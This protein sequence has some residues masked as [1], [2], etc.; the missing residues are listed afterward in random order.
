MVVGPYAGR[1]VNEI[2]NIIKTEMLDSGEALLYSEPERPV[3]S[4]SGDECVVAL[5]DQ[6]YVTYGEQEWK[7]AT[8]GCLQKM[9]LYDD[10]A[11]NSFLHTLD[12][13]NQWACSRS[14]GLGTR[15]PWDPVYL[16]E[17]LSDST[18]YMAY[19]TVAHLLQG[20]DMYCTGVGGGTAGPTGIKPEDLTM[21]V[22]DYVFLGGEMPG[23]GCAVPAETL[24]QMRKEFEYWYPFDLRVSGKD[25]I[26]NHLTFCL[27]NHTAVWA[28]KPEMWPRSMRSN[29][30]LLLNADKMSKSTGNFK[31]LAQ[32]ISEYSAD[33]MR[34]AL[35]DAGDG[36]DDANFEHQTANAAILR[37]TKELSWTEEVMAALDTMRDEEPTSFIDRVFDNEI[38]SAIA[39]AKS[40][41]DRF[42]FRE[43]LKA[44]W[45]DISNARDI[46]RFACG[47]E[48]MNKR[49]ILRYIDVSTRLLAP[50]CPHWCEHVWG[51]ILKN[52]GLV[53]NAGWPVA[54]PADLMLQQMAVY[55]ESSIVNIRK[56][57]AKAEMASKPKKGVVTPPPPTK[58]TSIELVVPIEFGG[59]QAKVLSLL[60]ALY[61]SSTGTFPADVM[62]QVLSASNADPEISA[63]GAKVIK[64]A[65]MPFARG[66]IDMATTAGVGAQALDVKMPF[67]E[68]SLLTENSN[69]LKR[70]L[71]VD[72]VSVR[73]VSH[74]EVVDATDVDRK[75]AS[76][77]PGSPGVLC[78]HAPPAAAMMET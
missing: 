5:T 10:S 58:V 62:G 15:L 16:I 27:Y 33:A 22:W 12:W 25:L 4:R 39:G 34:V 56:A 29:G 78:T 75:I 17:S 14:F 54:P 67:D 76:A 13:L 42:M 19:Y 23:E 20:G 11:K 32:A 38:N 57:I 21:E 70:S 31:T 47:A 61:D 46:Y 36:M 24:T 68:A 51:N 74:E 65:V 7:E 35:A 37:L 43:A 55:V 77:T 72:E 48:G 18:I 69:Y 49:L 41:F 45:Y 8:L 64:S 40:A 26:Q 1:K 60:S 52:P 66:R 71:K 28:D 73:I 44:G 9:E 59:W 63:L 2:K 6:W 50:V 3:L 30:H 53:V